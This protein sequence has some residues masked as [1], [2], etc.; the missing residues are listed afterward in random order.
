[1]NELE[2]CVRANVSF[3][4][5]IE[6]LQDKGFSIQED[7]QMNDIYMVKSEEDISFDNKDNLLNNYLLIRETVGKKIMLVLKHKEVNAKKEIVKQSSIKCPITDVK[8]GYDFIK[9]LNY[10]KIFE[11]K[12]HNVLLTNGK[13][14]IYIQ[15]VENLGVYIEM[16]QKN[17]LLDNN[18]GNTIN[19]MIDNLNNYNLP[20]DHSNYFVKKS[21]D[22]LKKLDDNL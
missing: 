20:F 5:L 22:M 3:D 18:N 7:F 6:I 13:N 4:K 1:M 2:L 10:K 9:A 11:I 16:E 21:E 15:D 17:L 12:D 14:E 8:M 19:E